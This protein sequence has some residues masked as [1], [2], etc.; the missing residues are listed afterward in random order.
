MI[1]FNANLFRLAFS[2]ASNEETY[3][4]LRGVF[5]EP[6]AQGGV[7]LT[8]TD[9]HR[10]ICIRD[11]GG[12]ADESAIINLGD[13]LK[14]CKPKRD[15]RRDVVIHTGSN[16]A[17]VMLTVVDNEG[18]TADAPLA[19]AYSV[20][21]DGSYPAYRQ[22]VPQA[23]TSEGAPAFHGRYVAAFGDIACELAA[24][25]GRKP[26]KYDKAESRADTLR[27]F[28]GDSKHPEESPALVIF[29]VFDFVFGILMPCR[30]KDDTTP[31]VPAWFRVPALPTAQAAE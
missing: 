11:E 14:Q 19:M 9:G 26:G 7:T 17:H 13:A 10:L 18:T 23:F 6:H 12:Q 1:R 29:P 2:C 31:D 8:A 21:V 25:A 28:C 3:Y 16:D 27:V 22:V 30:I 20:R 15:E 4:Y 24:H 5:V